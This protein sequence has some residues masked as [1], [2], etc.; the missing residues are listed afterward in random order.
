MTE[1]RFI[2]FYSDWCPPCKKQSP[3]IDELKEEY[4]DVKF[5][6]IDVDEKQDMATKYD[7]RA[8]PTLI[9]ECGDQVEE[10]FVGLTNKKTLKKSL[11]EVIS[12][13]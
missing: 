12:N 6:K 5:E 3:I 13:C 8:I 11:D 9:I 2:D 10:R 4:K 7:V 1:V